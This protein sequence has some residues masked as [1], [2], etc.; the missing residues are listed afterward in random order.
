MADQCKCPV[1]RIKPIPAPTP[2]PTS[3]MT[4][5]SLTNPMLHY[6]Y[7]VTELAFFPATIKDLCNLP[8]AAAA[9]TPDTL[10]ASRVP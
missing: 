7:T 4:F 2:Y 3:L 5:T 1:D 8:A 6:Y 9:V 10:A